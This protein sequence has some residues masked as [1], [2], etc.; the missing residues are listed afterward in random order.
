[1]I[2]YMGLCG[3][4]CCSLTATFLEQILEEISM[5]IKKTANASFIIQKQ[6]NILRPTNYEANILKIIFCQNLFT[7]KAISLKNNTLLI[8]HTTSLRTSKFDQ[9]FQ[10]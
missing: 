3:F 6:T 4:S 5:V 1:M 10:H 8:S 7:H 9:F 2:S